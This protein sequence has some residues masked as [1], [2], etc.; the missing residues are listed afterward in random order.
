VNNILL[1]IDGNSVAHRA[2]HAYKRLALTDN[3]GVDVTVR[4]GFCALLAA[5]VDKVCDRYQQGPTGVVVA[6]DAPGNWRRAEHPAYKAQ[7]PETDPELRRQLAEL[8]EVLTSFGVTTCSITGFEADDVCASAAA[9]ATAAQWRCVVATS[10]RDALALVSEH[11]SMLRL[12]NGIDNA[13]WLTPADVET[14]F[15]VPPERYLLM[16]AMRGDASD[17]LAGV[18]GVGPAKAAALASRY[19]S[20]DSMLADLDG[21][22]ELVGQRKAAAVVDAA[23]NIRRNVHLMGVARDLP[24]DVDACTLSMPAEEIYARAQ[25]WD[26]PSVAG[27][28]SIALAAPVRYPSREA[29]L[30][31][32]HEPLIVARTLFD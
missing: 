27:R 32:P 8:P 6:F 11:V 25:Q 17:N 31:E 2:W 16:A 4:Y 19:D 9:A 22:A 30:F 18:A 20:L 7:R 29:C 21:V 13:T 12:G 26:L 3:S 14:T 5:V 15:G 23:D 10:D 24:V 1:V 28:L